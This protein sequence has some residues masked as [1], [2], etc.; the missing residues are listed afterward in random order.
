MWE[1]VFIRLMWPVLMQPDQK[2]HKPGFAQL[3]ILMYGPDL[4]FAPRQDWTAITL[5]AYA[6]FEQ[7]FATKG[8]PMSFLEL[9]MPHYVVQRGE[10]DRQ[11]KFTKNR[12]AKLR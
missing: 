2:G 8:L 3:C 5:S 11:T 7:A 12:Q 1:A 6:S 10:A 4:T 9:Q